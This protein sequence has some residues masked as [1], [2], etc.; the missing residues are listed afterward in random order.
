VG[1]FERGIIHSLARNDKCC[2]GGAGPVLWA[3]SFPAAITR[4]GFWDPVQ[5]YR[6]QIGP[7]FALDLLDLAGDPIEL[8][9]VKRR[10]N[11]S[12]VITEYQAPGGL[13]LTERKAVLPSGATVSEVRVECDRSL[14][15]VLAAWT[16]QPD[17]GPIRMLPGVVAVP[18]HLPAPVGESDTVWLALAMGPGVPQPTVVPSESGAALPNW[19]HC[20]LWE[21]R[22][23]T[24]HP[25]DRGGSFWHAGLRLGLS[26]SAAA[27]TIANVAMALDVEPSSA[28]AEAGRCVR[29]DAHAIEESLDAWEEYFSRVPRFDCSSEHIRSYYWYR[30]SGL[31]LCTQAPG[32]G[33][34]S[35]PVVCEGTGYFRRAITYSAPA[36]IRETRWMHLPEV[37]VSELLTFFDAQESEGRFPGILD[38]EGPRP[39]SFYHADW[40][41]AVLDL[42][43]VHP[44]HALA[45]RAYQALARYADW[46]TC[47]RD[48]DGTGLYTVENHY[49]TG[50]EYSSRYLAVDDAADQE[51]WGR[52]FHLKGVDATV[53]AYQLHRALEWLARTRGREGDAERWHSI[54]LRI[55]E[56]VC[57]KM[58]DDVVGMF[59]DV[60]PAKGLRTRV[61]ALTCFYPFMTDMPG[62]E[63][64]RAIEHLFNPAKFWTRYPF[65]SLALDDPCF[66]A[67]ALWKGRRMNCPWNGRTWPMTN[68]HVVDAIVRQ[69]WCTPDLLPRAA[70]AFM[71]T[72]NVLFHAGDAKRP[73]AFEH[74]NPLTGRPSVY[75]GVDDYQHSWVID[76][77]MKH[78]A[79]LHPTADGDLM[80]APLP[81]KLDFVRV[82]NVQIRG[83]VID[84]E[85]AEG[86]V[87]ELRVDKEPVQ[88]DTIPTSVRL[89]DSGTTD[90]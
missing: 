64:G 10:W 75:R 3:P 76:L 58:W 1:S 61:D 67:E 14:D 30:W 47:D 19:R 70:E 48:P 33:R 68:S 18:R 49:E 5:F 80:I 36:H 46:L 87:T 37:A 90:T 60:D 4:P 53:Y 77:I 84:I 42:L 13:K 45:V 73:T 27:P 79:G 40:G 41:G 69:A 9:I 65:P 59:Y 83:R 54:A 82:Q 52:R 32:A 25:P 2:L 74:Y 24:A 50:Q 39:E 28:V 20:A 7:L 78:V 51:H 38:V 55:R 31:R 63:H 44:D 57:E 11:P 85:L 72:L 22:T 8:S 71:R 29:A 35:R 56:A 81:L 12:F 6:H 23:V 88:I 66:N 26:V 17:E 15:V 16:A 86:R 34:L 21:S 62:P 89:A 43:A